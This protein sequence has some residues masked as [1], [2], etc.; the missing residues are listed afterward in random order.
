MRRF[1]S[2][3][4]T[5]SLLLAAFLLTINIVGLTMQ[6]RFGDDVALEPEGS[7]F[8]RR[9]VLTNYEELNRKPGEPQS[10]YLERLTMAVNA[11][12][13][14]GWSDRGLDTHVSVFDNYLLYLLGLVVPRFREYEYVDANR[15]LD[16]GYG[17]CSQQA[18][19]LDGVLSA[20]GVPSRI[21]GLEGHV[22]ASA[23]TESGEWW[24]LDADYGLVLHHDI[25]VLERDPSPVLRAYSRSVDAELAGQIAEIY[26]TP[27]NTIFASGRFRQPWKEQAIYVAKWLLPLSLLACG[28]LAGVTRDR[29]STG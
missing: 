3:T 19:I 8:A 16:R 22:V 7:N 27:N 26:Q 4:G 13:A 11:H 23:A 24:I 12:M 10:E 17:L 9:A 5:L 14:R 1:V 28:M 29:L 25:G 20:N 18:L 2:I 15:A 21:I 6:G